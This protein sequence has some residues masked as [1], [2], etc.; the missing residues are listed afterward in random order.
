MNKNISE[1]AQELVKAIKNGADDESIKKLLGYHVM[2]LHARCHLLKLAFARH[3][4]Q[5][6]KY[7]FSFHVLSYVCIFCGSSQLRI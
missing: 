1:Y 3:A 7:G 5:S 6:G 2:K 4:N